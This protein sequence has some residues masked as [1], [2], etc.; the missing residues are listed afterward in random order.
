[1]AWSTDIERARSF[2]E[3]WTGTGR[4]AYVYTA[5]AQPDAMLADID[6]L[7]EGG[8]RGEHEIVVDPSRLGRITRL[9]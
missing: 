6:A 7:L 2:A 5:V 4:A 3:R 9:R 1:M 8:G